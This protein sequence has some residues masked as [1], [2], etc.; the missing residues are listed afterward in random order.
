[1]NSISLPRR[2][3]APD[4]PFSSECRWGANHSE[5]TILAAPVAIGKPWLEEFPVVAGDRAVIRQFE[6][7]LVTAAFGAS[8]ISQYLC[9]HLQWDA[10]APPAILVRAKRVV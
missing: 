4:G 5:L 10:F 1:M 2:V 9:A 6:V 7:L 8:S 3:P